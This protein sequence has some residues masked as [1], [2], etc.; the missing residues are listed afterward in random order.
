M[1]EV[2]NT[3]EVNINQYVTYQL[4]EAGQK[5][6]AILALEEQSE[7]GFPKPRTIESLLNEDGFLRMQLHDFAFFWGRSLYIGSPSYIQ[8]S[9]I[10]V[11]PF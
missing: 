5:Q 6:F 10:I 2:N 7:F 11:E 3:T 4:T 9:K 1:T 8:D